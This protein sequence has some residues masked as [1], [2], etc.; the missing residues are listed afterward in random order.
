[1]RQISAACAADPWAQL[2]LLGKKLTLPGALN[3]LAFPLAGQ[4]GEG[5][6]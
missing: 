1:M 6:G 3:T 2:V 5:C 4:L